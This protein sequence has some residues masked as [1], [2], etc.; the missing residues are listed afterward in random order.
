MLEH[1]HTGS[2]LDVAGDTTVYLS[3]ELRHCWLHHEA[4]ERYTYLEY[5]TGVEVLKADV[6]PYAVLDERSALH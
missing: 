4:F 3:C 2:S 5:D 1:Q 6:G